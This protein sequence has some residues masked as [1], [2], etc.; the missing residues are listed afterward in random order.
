MCQTRVTFTL[1]QPM[2]CKAEPVADISSLTPAQTY[3]NCSTLR[4]TQRLFTRISPLS[5]GPFGRRVVTRSV[6][7]R[8]TSMREQTPT[9]RLFF[10]MHRTMLW[11]A[12]IRVREMP[13]YMVQTFLIRHHQARLFIGY[14]LRP[15]LL[16]QAVGCFLRPQIF[17]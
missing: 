17:T 2:R 13:G 11:P 5:P 4:P 14:L 8:T 3:F 10:L 7:P 15:T 1:F 6:M 12:L 9:C 16:M